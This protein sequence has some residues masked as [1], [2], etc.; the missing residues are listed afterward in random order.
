MIR[1][2][3][4][5]QWPM[6]SRFIPLLYAPCISLKIPD[7]SGCLVSQEMIEL[8]FNKIDFPTFYFSTKRIVISSKPPYLISTQHISRKSARQCARPAFFS[9]CG[10]GW[11]VLSIDNHIL[12]FSHFSSFEAGL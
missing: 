7:F 12:F 9:L 1:P 10:G 11:P 6:L 3:T 4:T 2:A 8:F 5:K